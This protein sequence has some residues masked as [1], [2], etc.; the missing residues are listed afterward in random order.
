[1]SP[2]SD[3][4]HPPLTIEIPGLTYPVV[5]AIDPDYEHE[6]AVEWTIDYDYTSEELCGLWHDLGGDEEL[7]YPLLQLAAA[8][9]A[10]FMLTYGESAEWPT[11]DKPVERTGGWRPPVVQWV[12]NLAYNCVSNGGV[13]FA[14]KPAFE[15]LITTAMERQSSQSAQNAGKKRVLRTGIVENGRQILPPEE[16]EQDA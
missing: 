4:L 14:P 3:H 12:K 16:V 1:M 15:T 13:D 7:Q 8:N 6:G 9:C 2:L 10:A 5:I 11:V